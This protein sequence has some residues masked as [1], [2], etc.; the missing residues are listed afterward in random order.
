MGPQLPI[1][2]VLMPLEL[3]CGGTQDLHEYQKTI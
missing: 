1:S 2:E 3:S